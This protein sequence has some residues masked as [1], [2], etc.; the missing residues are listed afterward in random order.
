MSI[1]RTEGLPQSE[2]DPQILDLARRISEIHG[3]V[4]INRE[5]SGIHLHF[6]SPYVVEEEGEKEVHRPWPH[7]ALNAEKY[8]FLGRYA[9]LRGTYDPSSRAAVCMKTERP[10]NIQKLLSMKPIE[11]RLK[12]VV[13]KKVIE[14]A[15]E[16]DAGLVED[17]WGNKIP[18]EPG[19]VTSVLD[20]PSDHPAIQYLM[21]RGYTRLD[22]LVR[23]FDLSY[24]WEEEPEDWQ[25]KRVGYR[26]LANG[27][28]DTPQGRLIFYAR[29]GGIR[30]GWQARI[31]D[32]V[33]QD[34]RRSIPERREYWH[35]YQNRWVDM[36]QRVGGKWELLPEHQ[37]NPLGFKYSKYKT[38]KGA[39]RNRMLM[40]LDAAR[41]WNM[42]Q[43]LDLHPTALVVEGPLDAARFG[44]PA[45]P[46]LGKH[47]SEDQAELLCQNFRRLVYL[48]DDDE[49]GRRGRDSFK[50]RLAGR[51][52]LKF[53]GLPQGVGDPGELTQDQADR[54]LHQLVFE[55][56]PTGLIL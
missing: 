23:Q 28:K 20:L 38:A 31:L 7:G 5:G 55:N 56:W 14:V 43:G 16:Q 47:C 29:Q 17:E 45:I 24:C 37:R 11:E 35:P 25:N 21:T 49:A 22:M 15:V 6:P 50:E 34:S 8:L 27:F 40:T 19:K 18:R 42:E 2:L 3:P 9:N 36:E 30:T 13:E 44:P 52:Q 54:L 51:A 53:E 10:I 46:L 33:V 32:R 4:R 48:A 41:A 1:I 12:M 26:R 39:R